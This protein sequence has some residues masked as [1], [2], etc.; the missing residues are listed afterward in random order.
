MIYGSSRISSYKHIV[1]LSVG[2]TGPTGSTGGTGGIGLTGLIGNT[3]NTGYGISGGTALGVTLHFYGITGTTLGSF[4]AKGLP[5]E[6]AGDEFYK[7][8]GLG[9][10]RQNVSTNII[11]G[12]DFEYS[13]GE[14]A[15]FK[16]FTIFGTLPGITKF[17]GM[18]ADV[19]MVY[20][21][22]A[23]V[24]DFQTPLG[25]TGQLIFVDP[26]VGFGLGT[27]KG[28]AAANTEW[29]ESKKQL[30][31]DQIFTRESLYQNRN[32]NASGTS[33]FDFEPNATPFLYYAGLSGLKGDTYGTAI[34]ENK[35][36][37]TL[38]FN[39]NLGRYVPTDSVVED[40]TQIITLGFT[41]GVTMESI[42][43]NFG[44]ASLSGWTFTYE[45]QNITRESIGSCCFCQNAEDGV[46]S[47]KICLDYV[48]KQFCTS[49]AGSFNVDACR[50]RT[51]SP[52]CFLEGACCVYDSV[53]QETKCI[54]TSY[55]LC[56][57]FSGLFNSGK[58]CF[59]VWVS[60]IGTIE[61]FECPSSLCNVGPAEVAKCCMAGKC[62]DLTRTVCESI[63]GATW[64]SGATCT[65]ED[66]D[67]DC[68]G[69]LDIYGAC[70]RTY[71]NL[72]HGCEIASPKECMT[73]GGVFKGYGTDCNEVNCCGFT[74]SDDYFKGVCAQACKALGSQQIYSCLPIGT[75]IGGGYFAGFVGMPNPCDDFFE[76]GLAR[77][78]PLECLCNPRGV[79][80][81]NPNWKYK[82]CLG[83]SGA[84][85]AG[86]IDYFARTFPVVL[87]KD[88]MDSQC[89]LKAGVPFVQQAYNLNNILWPNQRLFSGTALYNPGRGKHA[90][91]LIDTGLAVEYFNG[92][93]TNLYQYLSAQVYGQ[94]KIHTLWALII[95]PE[96]IEIINQNKNLSWGMMQ[97]CHKAD[98]DGVSLEINTEE[99][100]T[101]PVDGLLTTRIHD[102]SS[103]DNPNLWFRSD[104]QENK[105][106]G[107]A[108]SDKNA[109]M[110]FTFGKGSHFDTIYTEQE[111]KTNKQK[112]KEAYARMWDSQNPLDSAL[113][114]IS[115]TNEVQR[116][117]YN[118]WYIPSIT[119]LN[120]IYKNASVL[121]AQIAFNDDDERLVGNEYW[122]STSVSRLIFWN[123][124]HPLEKDYY[125]LNPLN[126]NIEPYLSHT[127]MTS[128]NNSFE[129][130]ED[131]AYQFYMSVTN[132]Q[133]M[134]T[135]TFN[136]ASNEL[137]NL[138]GMI[139]SRD[140]SS[141]VARLRPVR[142]IPFVVTCDNFIYTPNILDEYWSAGVT[143]CSSCL[144]HIE[145]LCPNE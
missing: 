47:P 8:V 108:E 15:Y 1:G 138:H 72:T 61:R 51:T 4:Y 53:A 91:S 58:N 116:Y 117:G 136:V 134:L 2:P 59:D 124:I 18:S 137:L 30:T 48:S 83:I 123:K 67:I 76:P 31:I 105:I 45:P 82:T 142:R 36:N 44:N 132:G 144:D 131:T 130:N 42:T 143:G 84:D 28:A 39:S 77:G 65:S 97:G 87:P 26:S 63:N 104:I 57:K 145:G 37:P 96:D 60:G 100:P 38:I 49:I 79:I 110:R 94:N 34:L 11:L 54:N 135:Q 89:M 68:C 20:L 64:I 5:G 133:Q 99:I 52:D 13:F 41:G 74:L 106:E 140:R 93:E 17:V 23:T 121:N 127:R 114:Q 25:L 111:I 103:K 101:Y 16:G 14:T 32:W 95:A 102:S 43:F 27:L 3:G 112:F 69:L 85:N 90:F 9:V 33:P 55:D 92:A 80:Q 88:S 139:N 98:A 113:R 115:I 22:G 86:S 70:C 73:A 12:S 6:S 62:F 126:S 107:F 129:L 120:Y 50:D 7:I 29:S 119:E 128:E 19:N 24:A 141:K 46:D 122:S 78:E 66:A 81:G 118:D 56:T 35:Y 71:S 10:D 21:Y 125:Q 40:L 75:K 109:Y